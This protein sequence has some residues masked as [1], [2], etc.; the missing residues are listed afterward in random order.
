MKRF[1]A[2]LVLLV[3]ANGCVT[4]RLVERTA[5][6]G[7]YALLADPVQSM[8]DARPQMEAHCGGKVK[9]VKEGEVV[10][11]ESTKSS[12]T[13]K[14]SGSFTFGSGSSDTTQKTEWR[15]EYLCGDAPAAPPAEEEAPAEAD[16]KAK[17][18]ETPAAK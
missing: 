18:D 12:D 7:T 11:G 6:G 5:E 1:V 17:A 16:P 10:I 4:Y 8:I 14:K 3:A 13:T 15:V 2:C 9:V